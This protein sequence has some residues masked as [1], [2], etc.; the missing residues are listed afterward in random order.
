[1][2]ACRP[3]S[4]PSPSGRDHDRGPGSGAYQ[5]KGS[6][7]VGEEDVSANGASANIRIEAKTEVGEITLKEG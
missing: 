7:G 6:A 3:S 5:V 2:R 4:R 1:L